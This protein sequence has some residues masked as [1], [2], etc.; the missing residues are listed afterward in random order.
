MVGFYGFTG[1]GGRVPGL[2]VFGIDLAFGLSNPHTP[3]Q[4]ARENYLNI[5]SYLHLPPKGAPWNGHPSSG[6]FILIL[7]RI[8][9]TLL[10]SPETPL[11]VSRYFPIGSCRLQNERALR[12]RSQATEFRIG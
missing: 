4:P 7:V 1:E 10:P 3:G 9:L 6:P 8:A 12:E 5:A 2:R 11:N